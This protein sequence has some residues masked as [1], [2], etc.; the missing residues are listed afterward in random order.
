MYANG[1]SIRKKWNLFFL[2]WNVWQKRYGNRKGLWGIE[3]INEPLTENMWDS[4]NM[5]ERYPAFDPEMAE[6]SAPV[7]FAFLKEFYKDA[8]DRIREYMPEEK[9][10]VIHDGFAIKEWKGYMQEEK[11]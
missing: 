7:T 1:H 4:M 2:Y 8:Y 3:V 6:G 5:Q 10:V 9:Y 11:I